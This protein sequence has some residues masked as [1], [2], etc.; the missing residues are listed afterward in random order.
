MD[1][2]DQDINDYLSWS[3]GMKEVVK[4]VHELS[5]V[6]YNVQAIARVTGRSEA[7]IYRALASQPVGV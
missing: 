5:P 3:P 7:A 2:H 4:K 6:T 1:E